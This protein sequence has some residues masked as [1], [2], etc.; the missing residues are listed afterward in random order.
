MYKKFGHLR[1]LKDL[2]QHHL[3]LPNDEL[4][5]I[6]VNKFLRRLVGVENI[7][8]VSDKLSGLYRYCLAD[9]GIAPLPEYIGNQD[10]QLFELITLPEK[11]HNQL[12]IL[13]S[14]QL[15]DMARVKA[16][17]SFM[18]SQKFST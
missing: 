6:P 13:T 10:K 1:R 5:N 14:A 2:N 16:F 7:K 8:L 15:K 11:C 17:M 9:L 3:L 18:R 4:A 12:W